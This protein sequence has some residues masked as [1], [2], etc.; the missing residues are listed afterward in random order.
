M[1]KCI[2]CGV[3]IDGDWLYCDHCAE[4][5]EVLLECGGS[6]EEMDAAMGLFP[7]R[8]IR[9]AGMSNCPCPLCRLIMLS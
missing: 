8:S 9:G 5:A 2:D 6:E 7:I 1:Y 4:L 3:E